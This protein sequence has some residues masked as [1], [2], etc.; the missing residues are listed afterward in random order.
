MWEKFYKLC[1]GKEFRAKWMGFV[2]NRIDFKGNPILYQ[3]VTR[4]ILEDIH[5]IKIQLPTELTKQT[6][7]STI[8]ISR[9]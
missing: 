5:V 7:V 8:S 6:N 3:F 1:S 2:Q 9:L 4:S